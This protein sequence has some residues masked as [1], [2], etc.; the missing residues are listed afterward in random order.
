MTEPASVSTEEQA[1]AALLAGELERAEALARSAIDSGRSTLVAWEVLVRAIRWQGRHH[2]ARA[3]QEML[4]ENMPGQLSLRF[5][6]AE[7]LL[8]LGEFERGWREYQ[9]RYSLPHTRIIDR[10]VQRPAWNGQPLPGKTLLIHD[11]QG[12]G[13]T[14]Q[15][16][17]MASWAKERSGARVVV[18]INHEQACFARRMPGIDQVILRGALPPP[19]DVHCQMM[20]LPRAMKL[21]LDDLPG[22]MPYLSADEQR[23]EHWRARLQ[24]LPR[25]LVAL[26]WAGSDTHSND[27]NRSMTL[28]TLAPLADSN[29][30]FISVQ[31]GT[32]AAEADHPPA[33]MRLTNLSNEITD[34]DDTAAIL[35]VCD[36]LISVDSSPVHLAGALNRPAWLMLPFV[37]DWR[38]LLDR[39][40]S[41]WYP[42]TK[43]FRQSTRGDWSDVIAR[44]AAE[45]QVLAR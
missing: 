16:L 28:S 23:V 21:K 12:Y 4:V 41:P 1:S 40:D 8:L 26:V 20:S 6:L 38:W 25:P 22:A 10:K 43:L 7:T 42:N 27:A 3:L 15:F 34:F 45:L 44:M 19:F 37:P 11:E 13:D 17:R 39:D 14:F 33:G 36:L 32:R 18:Q 31:K 9:Y 29:V 35:S 2:D 24:D 5:D 30:S